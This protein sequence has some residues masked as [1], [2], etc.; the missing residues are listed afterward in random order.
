MLQGL[1]LVGDRASGVAGAGNPIAGMS[2]DDGTAFSAADTSC[3]ST[4]G[5]PASFQGNALD[6]TPTGGA[7]ASPYVV[8]HVMTLTTAQFNAKTIKR[9]GLH[10]VAAP[11][12]ASASLMFGIDGL[13][14][15]KAAS[16]A[17]VTTFKLAYT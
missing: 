7:A 14:L 17:L 13:S 2:V 8:S 5:A 9:I 15:T 4:G 1:K 3:S 12:A 16:F 6:A 11:T 10:N